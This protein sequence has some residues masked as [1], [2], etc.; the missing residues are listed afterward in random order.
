M[1]M[2]PKSKKTILLTTIIMSFIIILTSTFLFAEYLSRQNSPKKISEIID[3][4]NL[5]DHKGKKF[6]STTL[7]NQPSLIF[8]GFTHCPEVCP[9]TLSQLSEITEKLK[10]K[11]ITTNIVFITL[12]PQRDTQEHLK[13]YISNFNENVIGVTG[14][15]IDIKKIADNW[16]VFYET[17]SSSKDDYTLNHTATVFMLDKKGNYKGT[18]SWGENETS[19]IQKIINLSNY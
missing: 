3:N 2:T 13:D 5:I 1:I 16:G 17:I 8:F 6:V 14:N 7:Q 9:T 19:I 18:I 12:D 15:I 4:I 11:I 10:T